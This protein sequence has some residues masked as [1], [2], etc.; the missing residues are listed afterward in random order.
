MYADTVNVSGLAGGDSTNVGFA[1]WTVGSEADKIYNINVS[2]ISAGDVNVNNDTLFATASTGEPYICGDANGDSNI[3]I[4]DITFI[5]SNLYL[6][7]PAPD[8]IESADVN[9][10]GNLNIFDIT[11]L[12]AHLYLGG[13]PPD[14]P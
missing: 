14:C 10:D 12:I 8:P 11:Y 7:G 9:H 2:T 3:N 4:F 1:S 13:P 5:I 6:G